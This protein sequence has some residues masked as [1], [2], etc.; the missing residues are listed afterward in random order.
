[1]IGANLLNR[2]R[3]D[4]QLGQGGMGTVYR[5]H[6][7]LLGR[8]VAVKVLSAGGL[9]AESRARLLSE[10]QAAA[11]LNHPNIVTVHDVGET[12]GAPFIIMELV[13]GEILWNY[14]LQSLEEALEIARQV[15]A[16]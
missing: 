15:C 14:P 11:K 6:D 8:D 10:A 1:M 13:Q 5:A 9:G 3:I 12:E 2:Y 16:A 4:A 7:T